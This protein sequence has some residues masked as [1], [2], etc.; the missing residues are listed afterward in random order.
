MDSKFLLPAEDTA[1]LS[2]LTIECAVADSKDRCR[3]IYDH[4]A[5]YRHRDIASTLTFQ[6]DL[7]A[8][9]VRDILDR[10]K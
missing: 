3:R 4:P 9:Q 2:E 5:A 10:L 8:G 1:A 6:T 7:T